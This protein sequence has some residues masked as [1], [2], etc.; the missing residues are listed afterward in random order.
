M[1]SLKIAGAY[2]EKY[3]CV[4][5]N[6]YIFPEECYFIRIMRAF[7]ENTPDDRFQG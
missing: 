1:T 3:F 4:L 5:K 7:Y 2:D 6:I